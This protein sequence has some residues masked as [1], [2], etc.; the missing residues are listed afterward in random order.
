MDS[1]QI[2]LELL[3]NRRLPILFVLFVFP[4]SLPILILVISGMGPI[5]TN[6]I[7]KLLEIPIIPIILIKY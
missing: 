1:L 4:I 7:A 6:I 5:L 3:V 2:L